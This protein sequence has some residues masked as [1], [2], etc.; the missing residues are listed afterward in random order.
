VT[1]ELISGID[2]QNNEVTVGGNTLNVAAESWLGDSKFQDER[3]GG[4]VFTID[5]ITIGVEVCLDHDASKRKP[6]AGRLDHAG[7]IQLQLIPSYGMSIKQLRTIDRGIVFNVDGQTPHVEAIGGDKVI[8]QDN[9]DK[10]WAF[11][12]T[13]A[14]DIRKT[15]ADK[16][17]LSQLAGMGKGSWQAVPVVSAAAP[18]GSVVMYGPYRLPRI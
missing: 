18:N 10:L 7:N 8:I 5:G 3:M 4:C 9:D 11:S 15:G 12:P 13:D 17:K 1:K 14:S 6:S 16:H 2:Y